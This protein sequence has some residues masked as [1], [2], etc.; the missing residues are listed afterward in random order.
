MRCISTRKCVKYNQNYRARGLVTC[1]FIY[2]MYCLFI[3]LLPD[4]FDFMLPTKFW[5]QYDLRDISDSRDSPLNGH[6]TVL[7]E[8]ECSNDP[9]SHVAWGPAGLSPEQTAW[10]QPPMGS[11]PAKGTIR[12]GCNVEW[13]S[14]GVE[15][16]HD[17]SLRN[18]V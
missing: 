15:C 2:V 6:L 5:H 8:F 18:G 10:A 11:P 9:R 1:F 14:V 3:D 16:L 12:A 4:L 7:G 13:A 17:R